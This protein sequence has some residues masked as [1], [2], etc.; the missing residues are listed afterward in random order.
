MITDRIMGCDLAFRLF[1]L[2]LREV[3]MGHSERQQYDD[4]DDS[5]Q[6]KTMRKKNPTSGSVPLF[7]SESLGIK[8]KI[9]REKK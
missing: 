6:R 2:F 7:C 3:I 4:D 1:L 5:D 8:I 9:E